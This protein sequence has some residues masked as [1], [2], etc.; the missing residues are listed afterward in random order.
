MAAVSTA[1]SSTGTETAG[2]YPS[3]RYRAFVI[4]ALFLAYF[5]A[6][7]HRQVILIMI[8]A[9]KADLHVNDTQVSL[10]AGL[11][12][13]ALYIVAGIPLGRLADRTNRRNLVAIAVALWSLATVACG[14]ATNYWELLAARMIVGLGEAALAPAAFSIMIDYYPPEQRGR[15]I[16]FMLTGTPL[17]SAAA[18]FGGGLFLPLY[19]AGTF[20][21]I[22]P[23]GMSGWQALFI[24]IALPG[25]LVAAMLMAI[26]EPPRR[27]VG[28]SLEAPPPLWPFL[29][30]HALAF[31]SI[32]AVFAGYSVI[33]YG[34]ST[35]TPTVL[36][37]IYHF[38]PA[39][40]GAVCGLILLLCTVPATVGAGL[41]SDLLERWRGVR[42]R[43]MAPMFL[44]P[45][46]ALS[47]V[48]LALARDLP[49]TMCAFVLA[50]FLFSLG[51]TSIPPALQAFLPNRL[52]GQ[53]LAVMGMVSI[54]AGLGLAPTLI[55]AVND[56]VFRDEMM[57]QVSIGAV[58]AVV[59]MLILLVAVGLPRVYAEACKAIGEAP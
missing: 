30:R 31:W 29:Q 20:H 11:G 14:L 27:G 16:G 54:L 51:A 57:L 37:R 10:L 45:P 12:T 13:A 36:M 49:S 28:A 39:R 21:G 24:T 59:A 25:F 17:G 41:L 2:D 8:P 22:A 3:Q 40:A 33:G 6:Y 42:G 9:L 19:A 7:L 52:R 44:T 46:L 26:R 58:N 55:G 15:A 56:Y 38:S 1:S 4:A 23:A 35:W 50:Y 47:L 32:C 18:V 53:A 43:A 48:W 34:V 5:V